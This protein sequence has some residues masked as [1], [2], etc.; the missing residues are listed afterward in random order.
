MGERSASVQ[1]LFHRASDSVATGSKAAVHR[2]RSGQRGWAAAADLRR[3]VP[4]RIHKRLYLHCRPRLARHTHR[5]GNHR[6]TRRLT[7]RN[8]NGMQRRCVGTFASALARMSSPAR[9][10]CVAL[11][12]F[13]NPRWR[14]NKCLLMQRSCRA[15]AATGLAASTQIAPRATVDCCVVLLYHCCGP[16]R[17]AAAI[18]EIDM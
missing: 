1:P 14:C 7:T 18:C 5:V 15:T 16:S 10:P 9:G 12:A 8:N 3:C 4:A 11:L 2:R 6:P 13:R 17:R